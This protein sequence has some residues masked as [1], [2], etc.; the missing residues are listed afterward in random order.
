MDMWEWFVWCE[1]K[2]NQVQGWRDQAPRDLNH[3]LGLMR[4]D[5]DKLMTDK[6]KIDQMKSKKPT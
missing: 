4:Q 1:E 2:L 3:G 5:V 6:G